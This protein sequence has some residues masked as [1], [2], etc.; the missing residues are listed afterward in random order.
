MTLTRFFKLPILLLAVAVLGFTACGGDDDGNSS[1]DLTRAN[2][3]VLTDIEA[4]TDALVDA[5][6]N[7]ITDAEL[8]LLM[9]TRE[10]YRAFVEW[11]VVFDIA[12]CSQDDIVT[13]EADGT[14]TVD[15]AGTTCPEEED[16]V[17][18]DVGDTGV[19]YTRNGDQ[20]TFS[21]P[22]EPDMT[23]TIVEL[24]SN[25]LILRIA[26]SLEDDPD[27]GLPPGSEIIIDFIFAGA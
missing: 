9:L 1:G 22:G 23:A 7:A 19:T 14:V 8:A 13:F 27:S 10:Q 15:D 26:E 17:T 6:V 25:S 16:D 12:A 3:W 4:D 11:L 5:A 18:F 2:G 24:T 20:I 21:Q